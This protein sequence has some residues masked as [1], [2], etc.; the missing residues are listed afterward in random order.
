[1]A[2]LDANF[3]PTSGKEKFDTAEDAQ[4]AVK[5]IGKRCTRKGSTYLCPDCGKWHITHY[6]YQSNKSI[7]TKKQKFMAGKGKFKVGAE[8][9]FTDYFGIP[10]KCGDNVRHFLNDTKGVITQYGVVKLEGGTTAKLKNFVWEVIEKVDAEKKVLGTETAKVAEEMQTAKERVVEGVK[11]ENKLLAEA[12][13]IAEVARGAEETVKTLGSFSDDE[14]LDEVL[15]RGFSVKQ[16]AEHGISTYGV[17][18][19]EDQKLADELRKRG[20]EVMAEKTERI[21]L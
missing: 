5:R 9:G 10:M 3:C 2:V 13:E 14:L 7:N 21:S 16:L 12:R 1:M 8:V 11:E 6:D 20:Y 19:M 18:E 15:K 4:R 17:P